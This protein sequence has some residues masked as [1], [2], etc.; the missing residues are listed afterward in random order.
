MPATLPVPAETEADAFAWPTDLPFD[1]GVPMDSPW[2]RSQMNLLIETIELHWGDRKDFFTGGDMFLY[3]NEKYYKNK[4]FRGPD[5]FVVK[6]VEH[7]KKRQY[8]ASWQEEVAFPNLIVELLSQS[9]KKIDL[10]EKKDVYERTFRTPEYVCYDPTEGSLRGWRLSNQQYEPIAL[11]ENG[12]LWSDQLELLIGPWEGE[13]FWQRDHWIRFFTKQGRLVKTLNETLVSNG[14]RSAALLEQEKARGDQETTAR[15]QEAER[16]DQ[17]AAA[18]QRE[19][20]RADRES[21][22]RIAAEAEIAQL[23]QLLAQ[24]GQS[25]GQRE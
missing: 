14:V 19:A 22:A 9:T 5:F 6:G 12:R 23:K 25:E 7:D 10:G 24:K 13:F 16:A 11:D 8:W 3:F 21:A 2:H 17:E 15:L 18:R 20:E 1:D 4:D